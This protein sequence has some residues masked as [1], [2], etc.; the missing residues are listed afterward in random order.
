MSTARAALVAEFEKAR[1]AYRAA[2]EA[3]IWT[4]AAADLAAAAHHSRDV[5]ASKDIDDAI[6]LAREE[7]R[8]AAE[9]TELPRAEAFYRLAD[10]R[11]A[12]ESFD[13]MTDFDA[14]AAGGAK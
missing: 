10:A 4:R 8:D 12:L 5:G 1:E 11:A 14:A 2:V 6:R 3:G 13:A 7:A 9:A